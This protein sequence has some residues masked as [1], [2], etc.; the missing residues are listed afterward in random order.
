MLLCNVLKGCD[1]DKIIVILRILFIN[2]FVNEIFWLLIEISLEFIP[3][4]LI[5][6]KSALVQ[7]MACH[8]KGNKLFPEPLLTSYGYNESTKWGS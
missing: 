7:G 4:C 1:I 8:Q 6:N 3:T 5:D 2:I